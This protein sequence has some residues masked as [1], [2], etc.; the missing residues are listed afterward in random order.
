MEPRALNNTDGDPIV[1]CTDHFDLAPNGR[2]EVFERL[3]TACPGGHAEQTDSGE[4]IV[5]TRPGKKSHSHW[6]TPI[7]GRARF[8]RGRLLA[9]TNSIRRADSLRR[10]IEA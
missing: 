5:F 10:Q 3:T 6:D 8:E 2:A 7:V 9:E 4:A 1:F